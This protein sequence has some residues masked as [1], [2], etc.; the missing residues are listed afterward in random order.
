MTQVKVCGLTRRQDVEMAIEVGADALGF[1]LAESKRRVTLDQVRELARD[2]PPFVTTVAVV[3]DPEEE[4]LKAIAESGLFSCI[5]FH[6]D[7]SPET[8]ASSPLKAI[9][10]LGVESKED[11]ARAALYDEASCWILF[12]S[13]R[14]GSGRTFDWS[15]LKGFERPFILAG[16]LGPEN[17]TEALK[18]LSP[19]A[20]DFNSRVESSLGVKDR[21]AL[22]SAI[23]KVRIYDLAKE[24][25][26]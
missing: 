10:A 15:F 5:Q 20:V 19:A 16:G 3:A 12:D 4:E 7:E 18:E 25:L 21:K 1:I 14:G 17:I 13:K 22:A 9:K 24:E 11:T 2:V 6:G 26:L 8:V 23:E